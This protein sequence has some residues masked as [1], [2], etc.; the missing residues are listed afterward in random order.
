[1]FLPAAFVALF[2]SRKVAQAVA[3]VLVA[4]LGYYLWTRL[5]RD[6]RSAAQYRPKLNRAEEVQLGRPSEFYDKFAAELHESL[7][8]IF[9]WPATKVRLLNDLNAMNDAEVAWVAHVFNARHTGEGESLLSFI[10]AE[11]SIPYTLR[12]TLAGRIAA[13]ERAAA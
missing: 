3:V 5:A 4:A 13:A 9:D 8:G 10:E 2:P 1:M 12:E 7:D 11:W 6:V